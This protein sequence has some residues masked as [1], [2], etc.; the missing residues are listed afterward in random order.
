MQ[1][2]CKFNL[3][4]T[5]K[6]WCG[7]GS[8]YCAAPDCQIRFSTGCDAQQRPRG[9]STENIQRFRSNPGILYGGNG[10]YRCRV[11]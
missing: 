3:I 9:S 6:G 2:I 10:I 11:G 7:I 5:L 1:T 4:L 8:E